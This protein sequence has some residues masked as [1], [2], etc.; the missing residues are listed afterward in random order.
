MKIWMVS[1]TQRKPS[2]A[3][4]KSTLYAVS[5]DKWKTKEDSGM[6]MKM[7]CTYCGMPKGT[8]WAKATSKVKKINAHSINSYLVMLV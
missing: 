1:V 6:S 3:I 7:H 5:K 4:T 8:S 2:L